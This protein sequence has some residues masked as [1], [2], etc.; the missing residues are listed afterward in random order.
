MFK[1][2]EIPLKKSEDYRVFI[3]LSNIG[4]LSE[5]PFTRSMTREELLEQ[6][7]KPGQLPWFDVPNNT[8]GVERHIKMMTALSKHTMGRKR[9]HQQM[10]NWAYALKSILKIRSKIS[11]LPGKNSLPDFLGK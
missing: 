3:D 5:P 6:V 2:N 11:I 4:S 8:Q 7:A 10:C 1:T 9:R